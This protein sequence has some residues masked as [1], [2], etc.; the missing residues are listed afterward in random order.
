M[1]LSLF[2]V[3][4]LPTAGSVAVLDGPEGR[5]AATVRRIQ[6]GEDIVLSDGAGGT[7]ECSVTQVDSGKL[8]LSVR[9]V[10]HQPAPDPRLVVIQALPKG[11]RAELAV[12]TM[13]EVGADVIVPWAA[14][15]CVAVWRGDRA[16]RGQ[17]KW[18]T[19]AQEAA[20]QS[21]RAWIPQ[22]M[23]LAKTADIVGLIRDAAASVVLHETADQGLADLALPS[24]G[25]IVLVV[26]PEGGISPDEFSELT[27]AGAHPLRLGSS[28][29]RTSTAGVAAI[30]ALSVLIGRWK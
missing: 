15:H 30:S 9:Q 29:F 12:S 21:R 22:V 5:H 1:S 7:A 17:Q 11:D 28:V 26:G 6:V 16:D 18:Q 20:K 19:A 27:A 25:D 13:T 14:Q 10:D 23:P 3:E 4:T 24:T 2:A 8:T